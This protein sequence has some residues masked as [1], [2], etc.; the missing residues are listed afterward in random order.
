MTRKT[1]ESKPSKSKKSP[2]GSVKYPQDGLSDFTGSFDRYGWDILAVFLFALSFIS[3]IGLIGLSEG[4]FITPWAALLRKGFGWGAWFL[5]VFLALTGLMVL[6]RS[7]PLVP[8]LSL[9]RVI[10]LE[11]FAFTI[12][13]LLA[14][15]S[16]M[17]LEAAETG[18]YGGIIG[19]GLAM[20]LDRFLPTFLAAVVFLILGFVFAVIGFGFTDRV[21]AFALK[22]QVNVT[23][24][25][26]PTESQ[27]PR[28]NQECA[29][30]GRDCSTGS[31]LGRGNTRWRE[32]GEQGRPA[33]PFEP[34][35]E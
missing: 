6:R 13:A 4:S 24:D 28:Q 17:S 8:N 32:F 29:T 35:Q 16:G 18:K 2:S 19:W 33:A 15:I 20:L 22:N 3:L 1:Q 7:H 10:A 25:V 26:E 9:G 27:Q 21:K 34:P 5:V 30:Q 11:G 14:I 31:D 23:G 12:L